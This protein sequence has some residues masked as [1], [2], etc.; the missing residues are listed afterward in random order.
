MKKITFALENIKVF[1]SVRLETIINFT[2]L[3]SRNEQLEDKIILRH[4]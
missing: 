1:Q 4:F 3:D 2:H